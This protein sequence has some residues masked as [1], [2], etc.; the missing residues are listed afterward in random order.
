MIW[1]M[2]AIPT[3][4]GLLFWSLLVM[5]SES[6]DWQ[7]EMLADLHRRTALAR[8]SEAARLEQ[9]VQRPS[10]WDTSPGRA[11]SDGECVRCWGPLDAG[12]LSIC[13][14]CWQETA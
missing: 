5:A 6:D 11:V 8:A 14:G 10:L 12:R 9:G 4:L 3:V 13:T 2:I 7:A 1:L